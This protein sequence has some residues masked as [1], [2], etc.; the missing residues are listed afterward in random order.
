[1]KKY[2]FF[3]YFDNIEFYLD[4]VFKDNNKFYWKFM[5]DIFKI[6]LSLD[7]LFI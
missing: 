7:I 1:M 6:K 5:K 2:V 4:E 3:N